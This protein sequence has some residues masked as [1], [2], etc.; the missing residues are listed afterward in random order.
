MMLEKAEFQMM[1]SKGARGGEAFS[2]SNKLTPIICKQELPNIDLMDL[3]LN[4][5]PSFWQNIGLKLFVYF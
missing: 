4:W 5:N 1:S 2:V 3:K